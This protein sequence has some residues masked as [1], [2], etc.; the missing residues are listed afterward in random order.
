MFELLVIFF[1]VAAGIVC[2]TIFKKKEHPERLLFAAIGLEAVLAVLEMFFGKGVTLAVL[3]RGVSISFRP[4]G[5]ARFFLCAAMLLFTAAC[6]YAASYLQDDADRYRFYGFTLI[7]CGAL[8]AFSLSANPVTMYFSFEL[9]TLSTFPLVL[10]EMTKE[11]VAAALKYLFY[12]IAGALMGL[13]SVVIFCFYADGDTGFVYGGFLKGAMG[14][15]GNLILAA[16]FVGI[17]GFGAKAGMFPMHSWLPTA[18]PIAPA[19]ASALLS[20]II[21]KAG[22]FAVFRLVFYCAGAELIA[23]SWVQD[24]WLALALLT[25]FMG[26]LLAFLEKVLKK[27][28]AWSTVS[29]LSYIMLAFAFLTPK[30]LSGG[31]L[32]IAAHVLAKGCLFLAAGVFV[33]CFGKK[34]VGELKGIGSAAPVTLACFAVS[35]LSLIGIPPLGGFT[36]KWVIM[37]AALNAGKGGWGTVS[38]IILLISALLTAGY[39]LPVIVDGFWPG[40]QEGTAEPAKSHAQ[41]APFREDPRM[42]VPMAVLAVLSLACGLWGSSLVGLLGF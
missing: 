36:A 12:S 40:R 9:V 6:V 10:H 30:G 20:G 8:S 38:C 2:L 32:H 16:V 33:K 15:H 21:A 27:R 37:D 5:P 25:I 39:L 42:T 22:V 14:S 28:L 41:A 7:S 31:F 35:S 11:A 34:S 13:F 4:D 24:A 29:Q 17:V 18:H 26:S 3:A 23:G 1:P 19:P